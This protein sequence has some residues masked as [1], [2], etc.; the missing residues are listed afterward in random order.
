MSAKLTLLKLGGS[1]I[2]EKTK[3]STARQARIE[4]LAGEIAEAQV[5]GLII[6]HGS[7]S[8]GHVAAKQYG[9]RAGVRSED[10]WAGFAEVWQ[11][12]R[13]LHEIMMEALRKQNLPVISFPPSASVMANE[14]AIHSWDLMPIKAALGAGLIPVV[15]GDV[16]FDLRRGGGILSTEELFMHLNQALHVER[17]LLAANEP[18]YADFPGRS[19]ILSEINAHNIKEIRATL[20]GGE[21]SDVTGGMLSKVEAAMAMAAA[22]PNAEIRIFSAREAG[23]LRNALGGAAAGTLISAPQSSPR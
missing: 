17:I 1:L 16:V 12:A 20:S 3:A 19:A 11:Q 2:T 4:R 10:D 15:Y 22:N 6:G 18:V 14:G 7:G 5:E 13:A 21:G 9:T 23:D 8:F